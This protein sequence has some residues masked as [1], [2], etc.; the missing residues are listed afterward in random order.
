MKAPDNHNP[1]DEAQR[2]AVLRCTALFG[3]FVF[4]YECSSFCAAYVAAL[5]LL[6][7]EA[8]SQWTPQDVIAAVLRVV[9]SPDRERSAMS[10]EHL[11]M[12]DC[13]CAE[14]YLERESRARQSSFAEPAGSAALVAIMCPGCKQKPHVNSW[15]CGGCGHALKEVYDLV[16]PTWEF[17]PWCGA[18]LVPPNAALTD[19]AAKTKGTK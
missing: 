1:I 7:E 2:E 19:S 15:Q 5:K 17:C 3:D 10:D 16:M 8:K 11:Y 12:E 13:M 9:D 6:G 4:R 14:C 18:K